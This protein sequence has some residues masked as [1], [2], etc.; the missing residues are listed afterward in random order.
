MLRVIVDREEGRQQ[1]EFGVHN[2]VM[3]EAEVVVNT[4]NE[5]TDS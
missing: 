1:H 2:V 3:K 5:E 4:D